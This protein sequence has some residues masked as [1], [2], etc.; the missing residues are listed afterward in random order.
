MSRVVKHFLGLGE[1][2][3]RVL[4][5]AVLPLFLFLL[6]LGYGQT[7][8][9]TQTAPATGAQTPAGNGQTP[10]AN[11]QSS[12]APAQTQTQPAA[13]ASQEPAKMTQSPTAITLVDEIPLDLVVLDKS[14]KP[15]RNLKAD[16]LVIMDNNTPVKLQGLRLVSGNGTSDHLVTLVFDHFGGATAKNA[17]TVALKILSTLPSKGFSYSLL[18]FSGRLRLIQGFTFDK[19]QIE[20]SIKAVTEKEANDRTRALELTATTN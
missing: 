12:T 7:P 4:G 17:Q 8:A 18:D 2:G 3:N 1:Q 10:A 20:K 9:A 5:L 13:D 19:A 15:V 14:H 11:G 16:D 6:S